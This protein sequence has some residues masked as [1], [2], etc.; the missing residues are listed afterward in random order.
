MHIQ[1]SVLKTTD[2]TPAMIAQST[3]RWILG[4]KGEDRSSKKRYGYYEKS[5]VGAM[6]N[7]ARSNYTSGDTKAEETSCQWMIKFMM[8]RVRTNLRV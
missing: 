4:R 5:F 8:S 6:S 7:T 1:K 3:E 2:K